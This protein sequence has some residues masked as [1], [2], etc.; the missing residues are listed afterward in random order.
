[1]RTISILLLLIVASISACSSNLEA[2]LRKASVADAVMI[3]KDREGSYVAFSTGRIAKIAGNRVTLT[4][5]TLITKGSGTASSDDI[6]SELKSMRSK[7]NPGGFGATETT[8]TGTS[9]NITIKNLVLEKDTEIEVAEILALTGSASGRDTAEVDTTKMPTETGDPGLK[10]PS[11]VSINNGQIESGIKGGVPGGVAGGVPGSVPTGGQPAN[12]IRPKGATRTISGGVLNGKAI[13]L[14]QPDYPSSARAVK[15]SGA[16]NVQV[17]V[18]ETG[19]V[20]S[21]SAVSGHPLLKAA[22]VQA[23]RNAR[24]TPTMLSGAPVRVNGIV[25]Y[26]FTLQ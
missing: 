17:T 8:I 16:V 3:V 24:F 25:V 6:A 19:N 21:A 5:G 12:D 9:G 2:D 23:A 13:S 14:P 26:T 7:A 22:A 20:V 11:E 4:A 15:A 10:P 18:D 1:M